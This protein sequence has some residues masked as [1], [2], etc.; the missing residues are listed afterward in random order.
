MQEGTDT[1]FG[2]LLARAFNAYVE[3]LHYGLAARGFAD[4]RPTFGLT[5]RALHAGPRT[6]TELARELGV[7]KQAAA[8]VVG[9]LEGRSLIEREPSPADG[10]ATLLRLSARGGSPR[11]G[12]DPHLPQRRFAAAELSFL[13][14]VLLVRRGSTVLCKG[15]D[16]RLNA[17][18]SF[19]PRPVSSAPTPA[20]SR[21]RE[22]LR[23]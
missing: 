5:L 19:A 11:I 6:L 12:S 20:I 18:E 15:P 14:R 16:A 4:L 2:L 1:D 21:S 13:I 10:R 9:E 3:H 22:S 7:S 8:K 23:R 17:R